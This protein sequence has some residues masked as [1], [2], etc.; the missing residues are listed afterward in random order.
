MVPH[1]NDDL[2]ALFAYTYPT[3]NEHNSNENPQAY[4]YLTSVMHLSDGFKEKIL[5]SYDLDT[6]WR[7]VREGLQAN[8][9]DSTPAKL[10]PIS[11]P[12][13]AVPRATPCTP[14]VSSTFYTTMGK[15]QV[16]CHEHL[17]LRP[18]AKNISTPG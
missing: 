15:L 5:Q 8:D 6:R 18:G 1:D 10:P 16:G 14:F 11:T 2:E 9:A 4:A 7:L 13:P 12:A 17:M 3:S